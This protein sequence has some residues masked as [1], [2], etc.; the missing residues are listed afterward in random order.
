MAR[1]QGADFGGNRFKG[2]AKSI[3]VTPIKAASSDKALKGYRNQIVQDFRTQDREQERTF[4]VE[5]LEQNSLD[6][7]DRASQ[8]VA[9]QIEKDQLRAKQL[10]EQSS[11][12]LDQQQELNE[13]KLHTSWIQARDQLNAAEVSAQGQ[14]RSSQLNF[15]GSTINS[16]LSFSGSVVKYG[17]FKYKQEEAEKQRKA[18]LDWIQGAGL[19]FDLDPIVVADTNQNDIDLSAETAI[20]RTTSDPIIQEQLRSPSADAHAERKLNQ[21]STRDFGTSL[22]G[23]VNDFLLTD[24]ELQ[25]PSGVGTFRVNNPPD[26]ES[27]DRAVRFGIAQEFNNANVQGL[28]AAEAVRTLRASVENT[29]SQL[30]QQAAKNVIKHTLEDRL[31]KVKTNFFSQATSGYFDPETMFQELSKSLVITGGYSQ[32]SGSREAFNIIKDFYVNT[33]NIDGLRRLRDVE[34]IPGS[35]L[36]LMYGD[37]IDQAI[38]DTSTVI[39][40]KQ[41]QQVDQIR[42]EMFQA[43]RDLPPE[44]R[45]SKI[46]EY[47]SILEQNGHNQEAFE[48]AGQLEDLMYPSRALI[49]DQTID[50]R[51]DTGE[52]RDVSQLDE[53]VAL[54]QLTEE[55]RD[56]AAQR[57]EVD[58]LSEMP[59]DKGVKRTLT[60]YHEDI[61][62]QLSIGL[63]YKKNEYG[64]YIYN[65]IE[66]EKPFTTKGELGIIAQ[67]A[68][69]DLT[70]LTNSFLRQNPGLSET[71]KSRGLLQLRNDFIKENFQTQGGKYYIQDYLDQ[72]RGAKGKYDQ[73]TFS[74]E[75]K[76]RFKNLLT[77]AERFSQIQ[78]Q[79]IS[80]S[81]RDSSGPAIMTPIDWSNSVNYNVAAQ[82]GVS[83]YALSR[84]RPLRGDTLLSGDNYDKAYNSWTK[85]IVDPKLQ[86]IASQVGRS[87]LAVLNEATSSPLT[88]NNKLFNPKVVSTPLQQSTA[89]LSS[90]EGASLLMQRGY[91]ARGAAWLAGN[92][93][94]ESTWYGQREPWDDV[95]APAGGL[96]SWRAG[97][98]DQIEQYYGK[99]IDQITNAE[100]LDY[101]DYELKTFYRSAYDIF[102]NPYATDRQ[103]INASYLY[104]RYG[105]VG[106]RFGYARDIERKLKQ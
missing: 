7:I 101:L 61:E 19:G 70:I 85:G 35:P 26:F 65:T 74:D 71:E 63:G 94:Q 69:D 73:S 45:I 54:G 104:W 23:K 38:K 36:R 5:N 8:T 39:K 30:R 10:R 88:P 75:Q 29:Y 93:Q 84:Y 95:G 46:S 55:G 98:L 12:K 82:Q 72:Q 52:V 11:L 59:K 6:S 3:D 60:S 50:S 4:K 28:D 77:N 80:R 15:I 9:F 31:L 33:K 105:E 99:S 56:A 24:T 91:P 78:S 53:M 25:H 16:L 66:G 22:Y 83:N 47:I 86:N 32:S 64:E 1:L 97:R 58:S 14:F 43:I 18:S 90:V 2:S 100:Q 57:L 40:A 27:A 48:L 103:L 67:R 81:S 41:K 96:V 68:K 62:N 89:P 79:V 49:G 42:T 17:E 34:Q 92:I 37:D 20:K 87:P 44:Q 106:D 13:L 76:N 51:I 21:T 102:I